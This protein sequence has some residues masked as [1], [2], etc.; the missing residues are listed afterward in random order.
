V[1]GGLVG[2]PQI[3]DIRV[4]DDLTGEGRLAVGRNSPETQQVDVNGQ[5]ALEAGHDHTRLGGR[6]DGRRHACF[7][8]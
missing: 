5:S 3:R 6:Q 4:A 2:E 7:W 8:L 1:Q